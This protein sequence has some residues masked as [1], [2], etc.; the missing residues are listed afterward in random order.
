MITLE[1]YLVLLKKMVYHRNG[2]FRGFVLLFWENGNRL[3]KIRLAVDGLYRN[4][5]WGFR[6]AEE[7]VLKG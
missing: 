3:G 1:V 5:R 6:I 2:V 7:I 4:V